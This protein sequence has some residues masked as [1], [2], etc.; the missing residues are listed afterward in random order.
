MRKT[1]SNLARQLNVNRQRI[2]RTLKRIG[3]EPRGNGSEYT[4]DEWDKLSEAL[5]ADTRILNHTQTDNS[6]AESICTGNDNVSG[7]NVSISQLHT[8]DTATLRERLSNAKRDYDFIRV[9]LE[10]FKA[11]TEE[12]YR[13]EGRTFVVGSNGNLVPIPSVVNS[14]KYIKLSM[15]L[16]KK[17]S[18]LERDLD[19]E[20]DDGDGGIFE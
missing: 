5:T 14:E 7:E 15:A 11:E 2:Y 1:V 13:N 9:M 20:V 6:K 18:E 12:Y 10:S 19:L 3:I 17:I 4:T 16:S 8:I